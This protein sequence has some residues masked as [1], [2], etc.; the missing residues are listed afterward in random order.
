VELGVLIKMLHDTKARTLQSFLH[1]DF[2]RVSMRV[3]KTICETAKVS[4][5]SRPSRIARQQADNLHKAINQTKIMNPPTDCLSDRGRSGLRRFDTVRR[6]GQGA[7]LRQSRA[8]ALPAVGVCGDAVCYFHGLAQLRSCPVRR[9]APDRA[10]RYNG[11]HGVGMGAVHFGEQGSRRP[12]SRNA[13]FVRRRRK[14]VESERK[15]AFIQQYIPHIAIA[16]REM[17][18]LSDRQEKT[19]VRQLTDVLE[20]S[21]S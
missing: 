8:P 14:A 6:A 4:Q 11:A 10:A 1:S 9:G 19:M 2:S 15:K 5:R 12:L 21:R 18:D 7:A 20:R 16:L 17:L 3:A 13:V